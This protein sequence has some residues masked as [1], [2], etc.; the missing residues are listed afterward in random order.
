MKDGQVLLIYR[1]GKWDLP[2][3]KLKSDE[4]VPAGAMREVEEECNIKVEL[5]EKLPSTWHSYAYK[6]NKMLKK[7]AGSSCSASTI[8]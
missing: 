8:R 4:D 2:K 3:G 5:G 6:G 1:L 7:P